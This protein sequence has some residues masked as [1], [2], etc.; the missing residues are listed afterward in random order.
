MRAYVKVLDLSIREK[1][2]L[3]VII[4]LRTLGRAFNLL[5]QMIA[6]IGMDALN[7]HIHR[8]FDA[9]IEP[10]DLVGFVG[11]EMLTARGVPRDAA[12]LAELLR[13]CGIGFTSLQCAFSLFTIFYVEIRAVPPH[14]GAVF[15]S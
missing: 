5:P 2:P 1:E 4:F 11:P 15:I 7:D 9:A 14:H 6:I 12:R 10:H 3:L 13:L 8:R